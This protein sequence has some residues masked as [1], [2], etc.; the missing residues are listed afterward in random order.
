M[1]RV[2]VLAAVGMSCIGLTLASC[3][4]PAPGGGTT[5]GV[6]SATPTPPSGQWTL[7]VKSEPPGAEAKSQ[8]QA[9][10]TPCALTLPMADTS[11]TFT[12]AGYHPQVI[13]IKWLPG[14]FHYEMYER[15]DQGRAVYPVD[16]SPNPAIAQLEPS[17]IA[18]AAP[19]GTPKSARKKTSS[20]Q[21]Q[22]PTAQQ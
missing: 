18:H 21:P 11:V 19:S 16:F 7:Y 17:A 5:L 8:G 20:A 10:R 15:S 13:P 4:G 1:T 14:L 3:S 6:F 12:L 22:D 2:G 9:C